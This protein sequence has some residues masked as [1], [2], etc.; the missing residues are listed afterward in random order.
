MR[1]IL[2]SFSYT[3][4]IT[5]SVLRGWTWSVILIAEIPEGHIATSAGH[6]RL[7]VGWVN[8]FV[9]GEVLTGAKILG[10]GGG[11]GAEEEYCT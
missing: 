9:W 11:G 8:L 1:A 2:F 5:S 6:S 3:V 7:L 10:G 4:L